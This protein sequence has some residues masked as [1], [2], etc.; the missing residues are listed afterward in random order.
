MSR[1]SIVDL[2]SSS[3]P[4]G[5]SSSPSNWL[6]W[7]DAGRPL[8][9]S[10]QNPPDTKRRRLNNSDNDTLLSNHLS[11]SSSFSAARPSFPQSNSFPRPTLILD[12]IEAVDLTGDA[13]DARISKTIAKQQQDIIQAQQKE[14]A[15]SE[16]GRSTLLAYK[17][18]VCMDTPVD[19]TATLCGEYSLLQRCFPILSASA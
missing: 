1:P 15:D 9:D 17:C 5:T 7:E 11:G 19:A 14:M 8:H 10:S 4:G 13:N 16:D 6:T 3:P 12:D 2:T 18:P